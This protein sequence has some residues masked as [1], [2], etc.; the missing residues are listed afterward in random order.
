MALAAFFIVGEVLRK[1]SFF[2]WLG[3]GAAAAGILALLE[4][5]TSG[6]IAVFINIS[7]ILIVLERRFTERYTFKKPQTLTNVYSDPEAY[8]N[9]TM[10]DD[11][12]IPQYVFRKT[13]PLWEIKYDGKS[14]IMKHSVGLFYIKNL[15]IKR[16]EWIPCSELKRLSSE[17][18]SDPKY[19]PYSV[20]TKD[21]FETEG[22][23]VMGDNP[24]E[25]IIKQL[26]VKKVKQLRDALVERKE[27]DN[28]DS[29]EEKIDQL[30]ALEFIEK[31][32]NSITD[33]KGHP[34][35]MNDQADTDRKAVSAAIN[36]CRNNF[37][38]HKKLYTHFK[39]FIQAKG[40]SFR[41]LPDRAI[42]WKTD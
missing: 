20:M 25:D 13:G 15:I 26:S 1:G 3:F 40:N 38:E 41:Y 37:Q 2:L 18:V 24:P 12:E 33:Q 7:G 42:E 34:R 28:F 19:H 35:K 21:Q 6:Q 30:K 11:V 17:N 22:L 29:P 14:Y 31:Y 8:D 39:S 27:L 16:G 9:R 23:H 32:L 4:I 5:P 10:S 36:R